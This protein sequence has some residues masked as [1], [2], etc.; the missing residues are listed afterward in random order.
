M[1]KI[2]TRFQTIRR[3]NHTLWG[4][5]YL[6]GLYKEVPPPPPHR[7][8]NKKERFA[9][10]VLATALPLQG[11]CIRTGEQFLLAFKIFWILK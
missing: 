11:A 9:R 1:G 10:G 4:G 2:Y 7:V 8:R 5:T 6:Y 3:Q